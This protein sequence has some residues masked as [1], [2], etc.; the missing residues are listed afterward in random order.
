MI[1]VKLY[2]FIFEVFFQL[3]LYFIIL[4]DFGYGWSAGVIRVEWIADGVC[5][6]CVNQL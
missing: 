5:K 1:F 3:G 2:L 6:L 4:P